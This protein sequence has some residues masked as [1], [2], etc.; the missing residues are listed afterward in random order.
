MWALDWLVSLG[1]VYSF[2]SELFAISEQ[3]HQGQQ[4]LKMS[5]HQERKGLVNT[6]TE[7]NQM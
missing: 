1:K 5:K 4:G 3:S 7:I 6:P 2:T